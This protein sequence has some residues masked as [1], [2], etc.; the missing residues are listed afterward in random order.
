MTCGGHRNECANPQH[1][2]R[3]G[4]RTHQ[5]PDISTQTTPFRRTK[6]LSLSRPF[7]PNVI[8]LGRQT[9]QITRNPQRADQSASAE[10]VGSEQV[11]RPLQRP[12]S[13]RFASFPD[14]SMENRHRGSLPS[15]L[16]TH[17]YA[18]NS[19]NSDS[20]VPPSPNTRSAGGDQPP[21]AKSN[22]AS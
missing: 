11:R 1:A 13:P 16:R 3:A 10:C 17:R 2:R 18:H 6:P 19:K 21:E 15:R 20:R 4:R 7:Q 12:I 14:T 5:P 22:R 8:L 9:F